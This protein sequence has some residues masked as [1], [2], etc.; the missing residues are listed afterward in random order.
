MIPSVLAFSGAPSIVYDFPVQNKRACKGFKFR[1]TDECIQMAAAT[2]FATFRI[3]MWTFDADIAPK[4][5][6]SDPTVDGYSTAKYE[7]EIVNCRGNVALFH[8]YF[9]F[10]YFAYLNSRT[11]GIF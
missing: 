5:A 1:Y 3:L 9:T 11:M 10:R 4:G 2:S 7:T 8:M 6:V